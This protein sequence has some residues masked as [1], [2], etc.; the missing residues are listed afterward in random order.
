MG[1]ILLLPPPDGRLILPEP[2][3]Y[4]HDLAASQQAMLQR[5]NALIA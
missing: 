1:I 5:S 2:I 3:E 4:R